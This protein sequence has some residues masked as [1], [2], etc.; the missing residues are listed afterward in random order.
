MQSRLFV[1]CGWGG[2][3]FYNDFVVCEVIVL[4]VFERLGY[5]LKGDFVVDERGGLQVLIISGEDDALV[6]IAKSVAKNVKAALMS[7]VLF[8]A[9]LEGRF[10]RLGK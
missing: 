7:G 3:D 4:K 10:V 8:Y 6:V 1:F 2:L 5:V 9:E